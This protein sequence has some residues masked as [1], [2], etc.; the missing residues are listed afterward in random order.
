MKILKLKSSFFNLLTIAMITVF[1][2]SCEKDIL[3]Q[4]TTPISDTEIVNQLFDAIT[5][6]MDFTVED[7]NTKSKFD[8]TL[9]EADL[10]QSIIEA[11]SMENLELDEN[12]IIQ[13]SRELLC[14]TL[15]DCPTKEVIEIQ[16]LEST[17]SARGGF[18]IKVTIEKTAS[19][20]S[21]S[22]TIKFK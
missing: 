3:I 18:S 9:G 20:I 21:V 7:I 6:E 14:S 13:N 22:I 5:Q 19:G 16:K 10:D 12:L 1:L 8:I 2:T 15:D 17:L 4:E 11:L